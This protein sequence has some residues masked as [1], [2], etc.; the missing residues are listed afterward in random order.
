MANASGLKYQLIGLDSQ[1]FRVKL[2]LV[3]YYCIDRRRLE[4]A[5]LIQYT[6]LPFEYIVPCR[7]YNLRI[8]LRIVIMRARNCCTAVKLK[9][10][11]FAN[12][13]I[14]KRPHIYTDLALEHGMNLA[15]I[16]S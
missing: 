7:Q 13:D 4:L 11:E 9:E 6:R 14:V 2:D 16:S 5:F 10:L 8:L 12:V 1:S 15:G 3:Y